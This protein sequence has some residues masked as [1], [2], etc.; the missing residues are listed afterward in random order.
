MHPGIMPPILPGLHPIQSGA[1][2]PVVSPSHA[3]AGH[4]P[5][6]APTL[7]QSEAKLN[8][9]AA[10]LAVDL[11]T[12]ASAGTIRDVER[13]VASDVATVES[14]AGGGS[15]SGNKGSM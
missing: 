4:T 1:P 8:H 5:A 11:Q 3:P 13:T 7:A 14:T 15:Q 10:T 2:H 9:D 6:H 12:H